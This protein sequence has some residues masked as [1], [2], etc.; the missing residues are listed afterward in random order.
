MRE[1]PPSR[2]SGQAA[3]ESALVLPLMVLLGLGL[4]QLTLM[5][6]ARLMTEYAAFCAARAGIVWNGHHERMHDAARVALL[7]TLGRTDDLPRLAGTWTRARRT[8]EALRGLVWPTR[9]AEVP[10]SVNGSPLFGQVRIDTVSP[11]GDV[12]AREW[13]ELDFD[14]GDASPRGLEREPGRSPRLTDLFRADSDEEVSRRA[15]VLGVRVRYWYELR[16]PV[17]GWV[18]FTAWWAAQAGLSLG[19]ALD[20]PTLDARAH[21]TRGRGGL[22]GMGAAPVRGRVHARGLPT[23]APSEMTVLWGLATGDL[24]LVSHGEGGRYFIPL[25]ATSS[26]R[27]QSNFH[28]K[29]LMHP[30]SDGRP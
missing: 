22:G 16:V 2:E 6:Q 18:V 26:M 30:T 11:S 19:G 27:M 14:G 28:R 7:P 25:T 23:L 20:A 3:V 15:P 9:D 24:P 1:H 8:D 17:A 5:Q 12:W 10:A 21:V 13:E 4:I 29:W